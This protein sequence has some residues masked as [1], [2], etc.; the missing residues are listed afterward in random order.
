M[1]SGAPDGR[2]V[3]CSPYMTPETGTL[4]GAN[5]VMVQGVVAIS[6]SALACARIDVH[7]QRRMGHHDTRSELR[8]RP[9]GPRS[10]R[11]A[12]TRRR[13]RAP[14]PQDHGQRPCE[15]SRHGIFPGHARG[16]VA[17]RTMALH[18]PRVT[19][20]SP[21]RHTLHRIHRTARPRRA[22]GCHIILCGRSGVGRLG[23]REYA[24]R[25]PMLHRAARGRGPT[26]SRT[27]RPRTPCADRASP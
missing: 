23:E 26:S 19:G 1:P 25:C 11:S 8:S 2:C 7:E 14:A 24:L 16:R 4:G 3:S 17:T 12:S 13:R 27:C 21:A 10:C 15:R 20:S 6:C 9:G 18:A 22:I 5:Q